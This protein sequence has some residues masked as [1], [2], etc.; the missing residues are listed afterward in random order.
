MVLADDEI[1][2]LLHTELSP[3][4]NGTLP[5][6][7]CDTHQLLYVRATDSSST[8]HA[9]V[10]LWDTP[11]VLML[12]TPPDVNVSINW[13]KLVSSDSTGA[14][15]A[16]GV[17]TAAYGLSIDQLIEFDDPSDTGDLNSAKN[18]TNTSLSALRL[19]AGVPRITTGSEAVTL[20]LE[21][22]GLNETG[23]GTAGTVALKFLLLSSDRRQDD[24]PH[25][26][27]TG[28][29]A[30]A[31]LVLK[32]LQTDSGYQHPRFGLWL[33][34]VGSQKQHLS[35]TKSLDDEFTPGVFKLLSLESGASG[36]LQWRPV[37]Y[38]DPDFTI[39]HST[40]AREYNV[41]TDQQPPASALLRAYNFDSGAWRNQLPVT[42]GLTEDG[43]YTDSN[44]AAWSLTVGLGAPP[45]DTLSIMVILLLG[46]GLGLPTVALLGGGVWIVVRKVRGGGNAGRSS[47]IAA[48][49]E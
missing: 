5:S 36:F 4:C 21:S 26:L 39:E 49:D 41:T 48:Q 38:T 31:G 14:I 34:A 44:Y 11:A 33:T 3:G 25:L 29:S 1:T 24:L 19:G 9:L 22:P 17:V 30:I 13:T 16:T 12:K 40:T 47:L 35:L 10:S 7:T 20:E 45:A 43:W 32:G 8:V 2:R 23:L 37:A 28:S 15:Q 42:F 18:W 46:I 27:Q 6:A